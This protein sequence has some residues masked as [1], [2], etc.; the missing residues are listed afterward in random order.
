MTKAAKASSK[1]WARAH[2][3]YDLVGQGNI[4]DAR[5]FIA[6]DKE[7]LAPLLDGKADK[8]NKKVRSMIQDYNK[9]LKVN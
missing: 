4:T 9:W 5:S 2:K 3:L 8:R 6:T 1:S 7:V